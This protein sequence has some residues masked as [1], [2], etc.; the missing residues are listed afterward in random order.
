MRNIGCFTSNL[1]FPSAGKNRKTPIACTIRWKLLADTESDGIIRLR[2][3]QPPQ[4][5]G[6]QG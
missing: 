6:L 5:D 2:Q 1:A 3:E 4:P